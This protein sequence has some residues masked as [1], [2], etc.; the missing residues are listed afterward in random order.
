MFLPIVVYDAIRYSHRFAGPVMRIR[1]TVSRLADGENV[2]PIVL[3]KGD[4]WTD[5]ADEVNRLN[6]RVR[7]LETTLLK[8]ELTMAKTAKLDQP[9]DGT[10]T[11]PEAPV[12]TSI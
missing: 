3:R 12:S 6:E 8:K 1:Q 11:V 4:F 7:Q 9:S 2:P 5:V 10:I